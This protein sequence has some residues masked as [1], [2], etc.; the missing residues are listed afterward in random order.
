MPPAPNSIMPIE[1]TSIFYYLRGTFNSNAYILCRGDLGDG[2]LTEVNTT[3]VI[4]P[5]WSFLYEGKIYV[6]LRSG[7]ISVYNIVANTWSTI[8]TT[9]GGKAVATMVDG[10][11]YAGNGTTLMTYNTKN[12]V[13][14]QTAPATVDVSPLAYWASKNGIIC[15]QPNNEAG[16]A[17]LYNITQ[18]S[19]LP[20]TGQSIRDKN[21]IS[22]L[23]H[24][25]HLYITGATIVDKIS[26]SDSLVV[27]PTKSYFNV[28]NSPYGSIG[29]IDG[30][31]I[32]STL[33]RAHNNAD[34]YSFEVIGERKDALNVSTSVFN[35][36]CTSDRAINWES[37]NIGPVIVD[38]QLYGTW[39][40]GDGYEV[41]L[42]EPVT[43]TAGDKI[44]IVDLNILEK[45]NPMELVGVNQNDKCFEFTSKDLKSSEVDI[46]LEGNNTTVTKLVYSIG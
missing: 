18:N 46:V 1:G 10:I 33:V 22:G 6:G 24:D 11:I 15:T 20:T 2:T 17:Q 7:N 21:R 38:G 34:M 3:V 45:D 35:Y 31:I 25:G 5:N 42:P 41:T 9:I 26:I 37:G 28:N 4:E 14:G 40:A 16:V 43:V 29:L 30:K 44:P 32:V 19:W 13:L 12:G 27:G 36:M 23:Y 8:A 39:Q